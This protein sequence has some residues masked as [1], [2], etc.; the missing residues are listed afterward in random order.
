MSSLLK[1]F[2][3][4]EAEQT[5]V[6]MLFFYQFFT[7]AVLVQGRI[8]RD[9]LFLKRFGTSS[10]PLMYIGFAI[11]V[12][13]LTWVY[14][15]KSIYFRLD[16]LIQ[17][18]LFASSVF[19]IIFIILIKLGFIYSYPM[20]YIFVEVMGSFITFQFWSFANELFD[21]REAKRSLGFIGIGGVIA[22]LAAGFGIKSIV[23]LIKIENILFLNVFY[24]ILSMIIVQKMGRRYASK[25]QRGVTFKNSSRSKI[26]EGEPVLK[27][28]YVQQIAFITAFIFIIVTIVDYQFKITAA[29][30]F[31]EEQLAIFFGYVYAIFGGVFSFAFQSFLTGRLLRMGIFLS[32][33]ILPA[34]V[35]GFSFGILVFPAAILMFITLA[36]ASDYSFRY[37]INDAAM[38][39]LY[40][41]LQHQIRRKAKAIVDG[42]I[43]PLFTGLAGLAIY[44]IKMVKVEMMLLSIVVVV[45][46]ALWLVGIYLIRRQYLTVLID[47]IKRKKI[48]NDDIEIKQNMAE[49]IVIEAINSNSD[50][51]MLMALDMIER[52]KI[53]TL[54]KYF[55]PLLGTTNSKV[56]TKILK[57]LRL[58]ESRI[59]TYDIL[60][61]MQDKDEFVVQEAILTYGYT[62]M[63]KSVKYTSTFLKSPEL[64]IHSAAVTSLIKFGGI[65]GIM[66]A[67]PYLKELIESPKKEKRT[68]AAFVLGEIG[69]KNMQ[70]QIFKLLNDKEPLVKREAIKATTKMAGTEVVPT[71]F[72]LLL[73]RFVSLDAAKALASFNEDVIAPAESILLNNIDS[74]ELKYNVAKMLGNIRSPFAVSLLLE[75]LDSKSE[76]LR[77]VIL[78]SLKRI[79]KKS[80]TTHLNINLLQRYLFKEF[81]LY[82]QL[83][84]YKH[85]I[86]ENIKVSYLDEVIKDKE[87]SCYSRIFTIL[88]LMYGSEVFDTIYFNVTQKIV[89]GEQKSNAI[90]IIE[91]IVDKDI[92]KIFIPLI[93]ADDEKVLLQLGFESFKIETLKFKDIIEEFMM[94]DSEWVRSNVLF[95]I[96]EHKLLD[97]SGR[98]RMF[99][100]DPSPLVRET[101]LHAFYSLGIKIQNDDLVFLMND[102][103]K[104]V[105]GYAHFVVSKLNEKRRKADAHN[106]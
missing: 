32:L 13:L 17:G 20:L 57:V 22:S 80:D 19:T 81:Y 64:R 41:P 28:P 21:S 42:I 75:A 26:K 31:N 53:Y 38:Q 68:A 83:L 88:G 76:D 14:T 45:L 55:V 12:P 74:F 48:G 24:M 77:S 7:V 101:A 35:T 58:M 106:S 97:M 56:K 63:E 71:L 70:Q 61:L 37:T 59:Y 103:S 34:M 90:E 99:L 18:V 82:F 4:R 27:S 98:I 100:Y 43:K 16:T 62:M 51:E 78:Q 40:I 9:T 47:N 72:Y 79:T 104:N 69:Q 15:K 102:K 95:L 54:A 29:K 60:K 46:G 6:L 23:G 8:I 1:M 67:A 39:L 10:L 73:D 105:V 94:D 11:I 92:R 84:Y 33:S 30:H 25:L 5:R 86:A 65:S 93:E 91:N 66:I 36:R 85:T 3:I 49:S 44:F 52:N 87:K 89:S 96:A 2:K 50:D